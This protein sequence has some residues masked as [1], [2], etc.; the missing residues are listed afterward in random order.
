MPDEVSA[1]DLMRAIDSA[2]QG[3][4]LRGDDGEFAKAANVRQMAP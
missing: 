2:D 4:S 3:H 1:D